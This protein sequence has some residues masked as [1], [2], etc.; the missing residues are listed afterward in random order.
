VQ[1]LLIEQEG[2]IRHGSMLLHP[3]HIEWPLL[4]RNGR[5]VTDQT[6]D[7]T[8]H[9]F[10]HQLRQARQ[11]PILRVMESL[12]REVGTESLKTRMLLKPS[13]DA[14][15]CKRLGWHAEMIVYGLPSLVSRC[16]HRCW[17]LRDTDTPR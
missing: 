10:T 17:L 13:S 11:A 8:L 4:D 15:L 3:S 9:D 1:F 6:V 16:S 7:A 5:Y 12:G 14:P 2:A